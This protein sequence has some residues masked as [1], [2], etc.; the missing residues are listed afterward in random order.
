NLRLASIVRGQDIIFPGGQDQILPED[1]V[2][3]VATGVRLYD[4]DDIL[5]GRD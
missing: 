3:V 5:G 1:R 4:L 2:I